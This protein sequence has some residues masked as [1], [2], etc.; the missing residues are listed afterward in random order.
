MHVRP[1]YRLVLGLSVVVTCLIAGPVLAAS[2]AASPP[3]D[4]MTSP[5]PSAVPSAIASVPGASPLPDVAAPVDWT[6][7]TKGKGFDR[8]PYFSSLAQGPDG[9]I[10]MVGI[11]RDKAGHPTAAAWRSSDGRAWT[12]AAWK[13]PRLSGAPGVVATAVGFVAI[14]GGGTWTSADGIT[15]TH[16]VLPGTSFTDIA[17]TPTG[18]V[19]VGQSGAP[20]PTGVP[21]LW[22]SPDGEAW[23][24]MTL[25]DVGRPVRVAVGS[26]GSIAVGGNL[27]QADGATA[28]V[29]WTLHDGI[30]AS[31]SLDGLAAA[32]SGVIDLRWTPVGFAIGVIQ[33]ID[34][35]QAASVWTSP[36][37]TSWTRSLD[38]TSG[39]ITTLGVLGSQVI[40]FG[41]DRLWQTL[42]G[43]TWQETP[44]P[45]FR[46]YGVST[47]LGLSGG[48]LLAAAAR[49]T[50]PTTSKAATLLGHVATSTP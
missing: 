10:V 28:P 39:T 21:T 49:Y 24:S 12:R 20:G 26:D 32:P 18:L 5:A 42:D 43:W 3:A 31:A 17:T 13:T 9:T 15:W 2:P 46:G 41:A 33:N 37:G 16:H 25:G 35:G 47:T 22:S 27:A 23:S 44:A 48:D 36:D 29:T 7:S 4:S 19:A 50:G 1:A 45:E 34:G 40:A 38:V 11:V 6:M 30:V 14:G 8:N